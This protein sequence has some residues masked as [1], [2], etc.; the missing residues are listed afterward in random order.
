MKE[1]FWGEKNN[2]TFVKDVAVTYL[3]SVVIVTAVSEKN[4][5]A[6]LSYNTQNIKT[7]LKNRFKNVY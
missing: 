2:S 5:E 3:N 6:L 4:L 1:T 7:N